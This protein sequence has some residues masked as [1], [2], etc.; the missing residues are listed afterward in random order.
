[1]PSQNKPAMVKEYFKMIT[2]AGGE[3]LDAEVLKP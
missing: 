3:V 2:P 1:V